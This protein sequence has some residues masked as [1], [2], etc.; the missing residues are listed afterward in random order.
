V[1]PDDLDAD[2]LARFLASLERFRALPADTLVLPSHRLPFVGLHQRIDQLIAH[3]R[4]RLDRARE[5]CRRGATAA[6]AMA[7]LFPRKL[8]AHQIFFALGET[9][10]HLNYLVCRGEVSRDSAP[11][12][13]YRTT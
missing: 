12:L 7:A 5:A 4:E 1:H 11:V 8:D 6:A 3:H 13:R 10:A 2:P 9:L